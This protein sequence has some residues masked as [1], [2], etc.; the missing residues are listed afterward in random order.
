[1]QSYE[2]LKAQ[3]ALVNSVFYELP[4]NWY[5]TLTRNQ[6]GSMLHFKFASL[7]LRSITE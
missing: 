1:M 4:S 3:D 6:A 5:A 2:I 7:Q